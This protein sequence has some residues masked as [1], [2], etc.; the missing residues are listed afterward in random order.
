MGIISKLA[1][2]ALNGSEATKLRNEIYFESFLVEVEF[3]FWW[4]I[5]RNKTLVLKNTN[6]KNAYNE[7]CFACNLLTM[8]I[9]KCDGLYV[10]DS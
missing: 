7:K 8:L 2:I 1:W 6:I 4:I 3:S 10:C 9:I 5:V